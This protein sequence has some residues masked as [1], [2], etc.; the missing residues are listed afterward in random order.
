MRG[1]AGAVLVD[2]INH[3]PRLAGALGN[4]LALQEARIHSLGELRRLGVVAELGRGQQDMSRAGARAR[5]QRGTD[6]DRDGTASRASALSAGM[7]IGA[8]WP[9][10]K[11]WQFRPI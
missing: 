7:P 9:F 8:A 3:I 2:G 11:N 10:C 6:T 1:G 4:D 5:Q